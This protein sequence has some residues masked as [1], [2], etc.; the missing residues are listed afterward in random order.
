VPVSPMPEYRIDH[1]VGPSR[2]RA[3]GANWAILAV[4][5]LL[6]PGDPSELPPDTAADREGLTL[7]S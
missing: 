2:E 1:R 5:A 4:A 7:S 6:D 3:A